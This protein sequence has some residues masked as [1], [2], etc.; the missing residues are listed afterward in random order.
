[1]LLFLDAD[2]CLQPD[3]LRSLVAEL[4]AQRGGLISLL[5]RYRMKSRSERALIPAFAHMQLCFLPIAA[6]NATRRASAALGYAYGPCMVVSRPD[7]EAAGGHDAIRAS[8]REDVDLGKLMGAAGYAVRFLHGA[9]LAETRHYRTLG[10][11]AGCWR[12]TYYAYGG[13]SLAVSL[14]GMLG[15]AAV[16]LVPLVLPIVA[17]LSGDRSALAGSLLGLVLLSLL[18]VL[19][20]VKELQPLGSILWHPI[21]WLG[22]IVFQ[23]AGVADG[24]RGRSPRW[25][26]RALPEATA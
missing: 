10:E 21:T 11:I 6:M 15:I 9:D 18:R 5:T 17:L 22:T 24:L 3:A 1:V 7:Y 14:F 12:R 8:D 23:A 2:T 25:R 20:A 26:G 16:F 19:V 4:H 13:H